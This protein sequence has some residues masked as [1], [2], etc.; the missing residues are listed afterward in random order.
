MSVRFDQIN[1]VVTDVAAASVFLEALGCGV[2]NTDADWAR[3]HRNVDVESAGFAADLDSA[4][5][6]A[7][8][9]GLPSDFVG[10]VLSLR[11]DT[12][13]EVDELHQRALAAGGRSL[14]APYDAFWGARFAVVGGPGPLVVGIMSQADPAQRTPGPAVADFA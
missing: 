13:E 8:W 9:G 2:G 1:V 5:F 11:T 10:V 14:H 3:H 4:A 12:R 6:A 7:H